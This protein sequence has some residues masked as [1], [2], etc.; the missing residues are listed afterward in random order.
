M[1]KKG[2]RYRKHIRWGQYV[3]PI[4]FA[5]LTIF[6]WAVPLFTAVTGGTVSKTLLRVN[7]LFS[8]LFLLEGVILWFLFYRMAGNSVSI[9]NNEVIY[10]NRRGIVKIP[11]A[12]ITHL[13]FPSVRYMGGWVKI[14]SPKNT[15][16]LTVVI[17]GIGE[18]LQELKTILDQKGLSD[19]Y[20]REKMFLFFKTAI[21]S[22]QS[23]NRIYRIF[24]K[25]ILFNILG[26]II[27]VLCII[28]LQRNILWSLIFAFFPLVIYL[29]TELVFARNIAKK[30]NEESFICPPYNHTYEREI[31]RKA[32]IF[33]V[34]AYFIAF[35][36]IFFFVG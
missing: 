10:H 25:L 16:R 9:G 19:C 30:S 2:Y 17:E 15:I 31:Y 1:N 28:L 22:D 5:V 3:F 29:C 34:S 27:S 20:N 35:I 33:G 13:K 4:F 8:L 23:W 32:I 7:V 18:F 21:Y 6:L 11:F 26:C 36:I 12:D 14:I 24:G